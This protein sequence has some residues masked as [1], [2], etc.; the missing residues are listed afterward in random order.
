MTFYES[1]V[2]VFKQLSGVINSNTIV[3][4]GAVLMVMLVVAT[5]LVI[6]FSYDAKLL[7]GLKRLNKFFIKNPFITED[8]L[9]ELNSRMKSLPRI[10][11]FNWQEYVLNRDD[12]PSKYINKQNSLERVNKSGGFGNAV[13]FCKNFTIII[14]ALVALIAC[15]LAAD[16]SV[17]DAIIYI[18][19]LP[20]FML[21]IGYIA[22]VVFQAT[23]AQ[24]AADLDY[25]FTEFIRFLNKACS[26]MPSFIDYE[27]LF[28]KKEI[29]EGIPVLQDYL[30]KR[31]FEDQR[32]EEEK[33]DEN[34]FE[35]FDF[36][37]LGIELSIL[38]DRAMRECERYFNSRRLL[39]EKL[40]GKTNEL[41]N[42][43]KNFIE[44]TKDFERK[45]QNHRENM[46]QLNDQ[47]N[48]TTIQIEA[49]YIKKRYNE[50]QQKLQ[51][52]EK[53]YDL[54]SKRFYKQQSEIQ[55]EAEAIQAEMDNR[56]AIIERA[57]QSEGKTYANKV[58][59]IIN[60]MIATQNEPI[61][62]KLEEEKTNLS[63]EVATLSHTIEVQNA[64][65]E[66]NTNQITKLESDMLLKLA[67]IEAIGNVKD[68]FSSREFRERVKESN[69]VSLDN[70]LTSFEDTEDL[71]TR[72]K[73]AESNLQAAREKEKELV[74][75]ENQLIAKLK[76][77]ESVAKPIKID[78]KPNFSAY[79]ESLKELEKTIEA[80]NEKYINTHGE[81][82]KT[83][84]KTVQALDKKN[85]GL[86]KKPKTEVK[87]KEKTGEK[88][89]KSFSS[90]VNRKK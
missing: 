90:I 64:E 38:M 7:R 60:E 31:A 42:F 32:R 37:E 59:G 45:A 21:F 48:A 86:V 5:I 66:S 23:T 84:D 6:A 49:N 34:I 85:V 18:V 13:S 11:R 33:S 77:Q 25:E 30:E 46:A 54:A 2:D 28:T 10:V 8:N 79:N 16:F 87:P 24:K 35:K 80:E 15:G 81:L 70:V 39:S 67:Q 55:E 47:L 71:K 50:E 74:A 4:I 58:Y 65:I 62:R 57:M 9:V 40:N 20:L 73:D 26:T 63:A 72:L 22:I 52:L 14:A 53:D 56:K 19:T 3:V 88:R 78:V 41:N 69:K 29:K 43:D 76:K 75:Q 68:Y 82:G 36:N 89:K 27:V 61:F 1:M 12:L 51:Q 44:V 83:V 17:L